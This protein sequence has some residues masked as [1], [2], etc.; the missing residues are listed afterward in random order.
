MVIKNI[1]IH[2]GNLI[3]AMAALFVAFGTAQ[4]TVQEYIH[5]AGVANEIGFCFMALLL[6]IALLFSS[7]SK[8]S[9]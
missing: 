5:F 7:F 2:L 1:N 8:A 3:G 9:K 6:S 4:G